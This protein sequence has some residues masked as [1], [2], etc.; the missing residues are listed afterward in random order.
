MQLFEHT[1]KQATSNSERESSS[2]DRKIPQI[3]IHTYMYAQRSKWRAVSAESAMNYYFYSELIFRISKYDCIHRIYI[4]F[5]FF[6]ML[7][8]WQWMMMMGWKAREDT[9]KRATSK[10]FT[11]LIFFIYHFILD[12]AVVNMEIFPSHRT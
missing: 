8:G 3:F 9:V 11:M 7:K 5:L 10:S 1:H 2:N 6:G 12:I 4:Y